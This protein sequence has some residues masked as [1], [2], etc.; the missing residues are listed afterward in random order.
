MLAIKLPPNA[1]PG[2]EKEAIPGRNKGDDENVAYA[3]N[4]QG[5]ITL[6]MYVP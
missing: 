1:T 2:G 4:T 6:C 5:R 3:L